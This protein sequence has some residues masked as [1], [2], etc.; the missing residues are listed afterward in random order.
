MDREYYLVLAK[1]RL[2]RA[3]IEDA[4]YIIT[5]IDAYVTAISRK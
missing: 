2:D 5:K 4:E 3:K 1:V